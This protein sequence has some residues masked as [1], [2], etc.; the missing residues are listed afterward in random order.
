M[1][2]N[3]TQ[4]VVLGDSFTANSLEIGTSGADRCSRSATS[5]PS[6]LAR[7]MDRSFLDFSCSGAVIDTGRNWSLAYE[8][9]K[10]AEAG[11]FGSGT[12]AVL[13]QF[14]L[15]DDWGIGMPLIDALIHCVADL[16]RGCDRDA[17]VQ[18]RFADPG[19]VTAQ[20]YADRISQVVTYIQYY[21]PNARIVL[22]GYPELLNLDSAAACIDILGV[23]LLV[24]PRAAALV[25]YLQSLGRAQAGAAELL[26][27]DYFDT[28][29]VS[30]G[31][32]LCTPDPWV[33]GLGNPRADLL[34]IPGHP[35]ARGDASTAAELKSQL[36]L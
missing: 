22:V 27:I 14:G 7:S 35:S 36:G 16:I 30:R 20:R 8:A 31:H 10:A 28:A 19:K 3:G 15:N 33:N 13:L 9:K 5:W 11:A 2:N 18:N 6:Q 25:D 12:D 21:A 4:V 24:Q 34:G 29:A 17:V 23:P 32:G 1:A 26:G